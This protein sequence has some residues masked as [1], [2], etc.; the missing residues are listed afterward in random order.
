MKR[1]ISVIIIVICVCFMSCFQNQE[2]SGYVEKREE[3][4]RINTCINNFKLKNIA[5][6]VIKEN[7]EFDKENLELLIENNALKK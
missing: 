7:L 4:S 6:E 1:I 2:D 5:K 3:R